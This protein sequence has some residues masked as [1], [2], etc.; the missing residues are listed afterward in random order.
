MFAPKS[1]QSNLSLR[2]KFFALDF[3]L[4]FSILILGIISMFAM[5]STDGGEISFHTKSH[6]F[7][8]II[9]FSMMIVISFI[10]IKFW[11]GCLEDHPSLV[12]SN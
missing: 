5:Y 9:F 8:F 6:F 12:A 1:I 3:I 11:L 4:V 10:N 2:E 7:K